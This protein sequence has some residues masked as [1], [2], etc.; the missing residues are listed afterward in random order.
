MSNANMHTVNYI[1]AED[2]DEKN[3]FMG[4]RHV[5]KEIFSQKRITRL[6]ELNSDNF[7]GFTITHTFGDTQL[8]IE[9]DCMFLDN[10]ES[11]PFVTKLTLRACFNYRTKFH[12]MLWRGHS[13]HAIFEFE[14]RVPDV[15]KSIKFHGQRKRWDP[16]LIICSKLD[17]DICWNILKTSKQEFEQFMK[18]QNPHI[19][20]ANKI[21]EEEFKKN[22]K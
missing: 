3:H 5:Q 1:R 14:S 9:F 22:L 11:E 12:T 15:V 7:V 6:E 4:L 16:N 18:E 8:P 2:R 19:Y 20:E 17:A 13:H 10:F 21:E